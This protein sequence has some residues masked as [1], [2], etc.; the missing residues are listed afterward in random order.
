MSY[1]FITV[2]PNWNRTW[3]TYTI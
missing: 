3:C 1:V 2:V